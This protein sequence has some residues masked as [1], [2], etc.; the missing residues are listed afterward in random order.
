ME[1]SLN[2]ELILKWY[3]KKY[4]TGLKCLHLSSQKGIFLRLS[5]LNIIKLYKISLKVG[6]FMIRSLSLRGWA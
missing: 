4:T 1:E 2:L 6:N 3:G 5:T